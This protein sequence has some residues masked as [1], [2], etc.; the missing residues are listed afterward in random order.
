M[1]DLISCSAVFYRIEAENRSEKITEPA[2]RKYTLYLSV[3]SPNV[4]K[5]GSEKLRIRTLF[6]QS[7]N[8]LF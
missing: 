4:V 2:K 5:Y 7:M 1:I 8:E 6:M 3:F